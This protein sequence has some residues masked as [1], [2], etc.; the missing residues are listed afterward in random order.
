MVLM[1]ESRG[2]NFSWGRIRKG[3]A[4]IKDNRVRPSRFYDVTPNNLT[5]SN[6]V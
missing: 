6:P 2:V 4:K 3:R 5:K 1:G